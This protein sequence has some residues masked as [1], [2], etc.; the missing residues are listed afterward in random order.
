M[1]LPVR[2]TLD[3][4]DAVCGYL[5]AKPTGATTAEAR[6]VVDK[7]HLDGRKLTGLKV[8]G[9]IEDA[10]GKL[11]ITD[12]GREAVRES[13]AYRSTALRQVL[14]DISP[15]TAVIERVA[16]RGETS[17]SAIDVASHWH[18]HFREQS[19][20][21]EETLNNQ[22]LTFFQVAQGA[23]LGVV[24]LG[25]KGRPTRFDFDRD[26]VQ[27]FIAVA[28]TGEREEPRAE[29]MEDE[30]PPRNE[31]TEDQPI[32]VQI[33]IWHRD[34]DEPLEQ[35]KGILD[36]WKIPYLT[37]EAEPNTGSPISED[38]AQ[39]M[40]ACTAAIFLLTNVRSE[41]SED[42]AYE[43]GAAS[44]LYGRK[45]VILQDAEVSPSPRF[46]DI[47]EIVFQEDNILDVEISL[48]KAMLAFDAV[49]LVST[50]SR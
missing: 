16:H 18:E 33:F 14:R 42:F 2:T 45:I 9:L 22:A 23:D 12:L 17:L 37:A 34:R 28:E 1:A 7:K 19:S 38:V 30:S 32:P 48:L 10:E 47:G 39:A 43:L 50:A 21:S 41:P 4:I 25:R 15:Y 40:R 27:G 3:D 24:V 44:V 35:L 20:E 5:A 36:E 31:P 26:A 46:S 11:K 8:W 13:G 6:A 29:T 49:R